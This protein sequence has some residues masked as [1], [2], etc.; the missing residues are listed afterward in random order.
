[1]EAKQ[2]LAALIDAYSDAKRTGN[3]NLIRMAAGPLQEFLS[4]HDIVPVAEPIA[5]VAAPEA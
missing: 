1:M 4:G 5:E 3:E 2:T